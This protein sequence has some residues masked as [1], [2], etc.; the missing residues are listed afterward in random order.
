[1]NTSPREYIQEKD[2]VLLA[3]TWNVNGRGPDPNVDI[4]PWLFPRLRQ[5]HSSVDVYLIGLQEIQVL[6]GVDAVRTD[7]VKGIA[8][9]KKIQACLGSDYEKVA[10]RQLV[11]IMVFVFIRK[12]HIPFL[13]NVQL[14]YAATGFFNAVGNKGGVA[15]RFMLYNRTISCVACHLAAHTANVERRNQDFTDV[16]RKAVFYPLEMG[17]DEL[18]RSMSMLESTSVTEQPDLKGQSRSS[19]ESS[20]AINNFTSFGLA[21]SVSGSTS[22]LGS[23]ASVAATAFYDISAGANTTI[24]NDPN[25]I[26]A[27]DHD[28]LFWLGDLNYRI[29]GPADHILKCIEDKDWDSLYRSDQLQRQMKTCKVFLGFKE[30]PLQFPPTYKLERYTDNYASD[31]NGMVKRAP[32]YT[33][34]ILWRIGGDEEDHHGAPNL[35]L[36]DYSSA[37]SVFSSDHRPV[38]AIFSMTFG[39]EDFARRRDIELKIKNGLDDQEAQPRPSIQVT[40]PIVDFGDLFYEQKCERAVKLRNVGSIPFT[41]SIKMPAVIPRWLNFDASHLNGSK[42]QP[43]DAISFRMNALVT[44]EFGVAN[45][46]C[47]TGCNVE[48]NMLISTEPESL[49]KPILMRGRYVATTLG[50]SLETLSMLAD[51]VL[52][53]RTSLPEKNHGN[54]RKSEDDEYRSSPSIVPL[55][56]PKEIWLLVDALMRVHEGDNDPYLN[57]FPS[58]FLSDADEAQVQRALAFIDRAE[59]IPDELDGEAIAACIVR[60]LEKMNG[61]VIPSYAYRRAIEAGHTDDGNVVRAV[62]NLL[63]P[64]NVNV[65]WYIIGFLCELPAVRNKDGRQKSIARIFGKV[66][67]RTKNISTTRDERSKTA[68]IMAAMWFQR[69]TSANDY[70]SVIDLI[71]PRLHPRRLEKS[72]IVQ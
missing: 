4:S 48:T 65:F 62:V 63:P 47:N 34:R 18:S 3:G 43:G 64:L 25:A 52:L 20:S 55:S 60:V 38:Y 53:L 31:E 61:S 46:L 13:S 1:M 57:K 71:T 6:S 17:Q 50:L 2:L 14:S 45:T 67:I 66:L 37:Q 33:D 39:V 23:V 8:W 44:S 9:R 70:T 10:E 16:V 7:P 32:A 28:V 42:L 72:E 49:D 22:W 59:R 26:K 68:F 56:I 21:S 30:G 27:V 41:I 29:E 58:L 36:E 69:R 12:N 51:P 35:R 19:I 5:P 40:P 11:G 15:A 54:L 24:L